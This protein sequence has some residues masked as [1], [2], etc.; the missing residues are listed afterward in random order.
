[1]KKRSDAIYQLSELVILLLFTF[2]AVEGVLELKKQPSSKP[3]IYT[4][5]VRLQF[6]R[7]KRIKAKNLIRNI[8]IWI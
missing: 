4:F 6:A 5:G 8:A 2:E 7:S 3:E 1:M